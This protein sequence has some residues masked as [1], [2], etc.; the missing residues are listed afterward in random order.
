MKITSNLAT[1]A[2]FGQERV[3]QAKQRVSTAARLT[4]AQLAQLE[5]VAHNSSEQLVAWVDEQ[6]EP[7][8]DAIILLLTDGES[9]IRAPV[10]VYMSL[11]AEMVDDL[12]AVAEDSGQTRAA[13][14]RHVIQLGLGQL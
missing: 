4:R 1:V 7:I 12:D 5:Q 6:P 9:E 10:R 11:P 3:A 14:L 8:A 13:V 2:L